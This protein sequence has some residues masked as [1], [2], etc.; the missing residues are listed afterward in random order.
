M[1]MDSNPKTKYI[2]HPKIIQEKLNIKK[3]RITPRFI[4]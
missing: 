4:F 2:N 3:A 1:V